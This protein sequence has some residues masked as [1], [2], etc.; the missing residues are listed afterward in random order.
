MSLIIFIFSSS[1]NRLS[2]M[3]CSSAILGVKITDDS[4]KR[5]LPKP[6]FIVSSD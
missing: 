6:L 5:V 3:S 1:F 2:G 4:T